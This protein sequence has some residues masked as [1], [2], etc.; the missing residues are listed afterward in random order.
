MHIYSLGEPC[1]EQLQG[2]TAPLFTARMSP[3]ACHRHVYNRFCEEDAWVVPYH[4]AVL[5][6]WN[7]HMNLQAVTDAAWSYYLLKY[8]AKEQLPTNL[9]LDGKALAALGLDSIGKQQAALATAVVMSRPVC[10]CEAA[11]IT[12]GVP[13]VQ[14]SDSVTYVDT[15]PPPLR[16]LFVKNDVAYGGKS[17]LATYVS[18]PHDP[19]FD[20]LTL[21][22]YFSNYEVSRRL[23]QQ[24]PRPHLGC[25]WDFQPNLFDWASTCVNM[26]DS[27][28]NCSHPSAVDTY[29]H[30]YVHAPIHFIHVALQVMIPKEEICD[31]F[32]C[33]YCCCRCLLSPRCAAGAT[34]P[35]LG[36]WTATP[37]TA[38][39]TSWA[40][41]YGTCRSHASSGGQWATPSAHTCPFITTCSSRTSPS[42]TSRPCCGPTA[43][44]LSSA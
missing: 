14:C 29:L 2:G 11:L 35:P 10:P 1:L 26:P 43:T 31:F 44:T 9:V 20:E 13:I 25:T 6:A 17:T 27:L 19:E 5:L 30:A 8:A 7:A 3:A 37:T 12:S 16:T 15:R 39:Q 28:A 42:G 33:C 38:A 34:R 40:V 41:T 32:C 18:R 21:P 4:P 23:G 22:E 24:V 36:A